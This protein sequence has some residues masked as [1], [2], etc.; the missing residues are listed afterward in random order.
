MVQTRHTWLVR[1]HCRLH[2][3]LMDNASSWPWL[4]ASQVGRTCKPFER[5]PGAGAPL[6]TAR[7]AFVSAA[8]RQQLPATSCQSCARIAPQGVNSPLCSHGD[9]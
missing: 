7:T 6:P 4:S 9:S 2:V 3:L 1:L 5:L 8:V